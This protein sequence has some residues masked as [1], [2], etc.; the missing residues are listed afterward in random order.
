MFDYTHLHPMTVHFPIVLIIVGF[1]FETYSMF[2]SKKEPCLSKIGFYIMLIGTLAAVSAFF[3]GDLFTEELNGKAGELEETHELFAKITMFI[4][5]AATLLR[6]Y[7]FFTHKENSWNKWL[8]YCVY[9]VAAVCVGYTG[10]LGGTL[11][12]NYM[13]R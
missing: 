2:F 11:V 3:S 6:S 1:L 8:V 5:I 13:I 12:Y 9:A 10:L 7:I 4:M